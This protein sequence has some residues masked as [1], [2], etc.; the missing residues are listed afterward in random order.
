MYG[1][2]SSA[3]DTQKIR[4]VIEI[5]RSGSFTRA[6]KQ[7]GTSQPALS[8]SIARLEDILGAPLFE[9]SGEGASPTPLAEFIVSRGELAI[10]AIAALDHD[11]RMLARG[12]AGRLVLGVGPY[13]TELLLAPLTERLMREFPALSLRTVTH[14]GRDLLELLSDRKIDLVLGARGDRSTDEV[15]QVAG[16]RVTPLF[17][18]R[19]F[20]FTRPDHPC[21]KPEHRLKLIELLEFPFAGPGLTKQQLDIFPAPL[22]R[23]QRHNLNAVMTHNHNVVKHLMLT[24]NVIGYAIGNIYSNEIREGHLVR[25]SVDREWPHYCAAFANPESR[26]SVIVERC[27]EIAGELAKD[28]NLDFEPSP[29]INPKGSPKQRA[30]RL[31]PNS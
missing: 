27:I 31:S 8:R 25:L 13:I 29:K 18:S 12:A 26:H 20:F 10:H 16:L 15:E 1:V 11:A 21:A 22:A 28:L 9:R 5:T 7:L 30:V 6:A 19:V 24:S 2:E 14:F 17:T 23:R 4:Q 3:M